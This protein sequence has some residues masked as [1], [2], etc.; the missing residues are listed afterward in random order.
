M[1]DASELKEEGWDMRTR[2]FYFCSVLVEQGMS[3][4]AQDRDEMQP[5]VLQDHRLCLEVWARMNCQSKEDKIVEMFL[6]T[7]LV[8]HL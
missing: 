8:Q 1:E 5:R 4:E 2:K 7:L 3:V 6:P